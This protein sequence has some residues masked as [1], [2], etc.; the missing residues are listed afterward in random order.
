M[1]GGDVANTGGGPQRAERIPNAPGHALKTR[2]QWLNPKEF[3]VPA[4]FTFGNERRNDLVGPGYLNVDFNARKDFTMERLTIQFRC[5]F[6]NLFNRTQLAL[7]S[8][9][10]QSSAF[11]SI[12][13]T[14]APAREIQFVLK[15]L[16]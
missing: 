15:A 16:F 6:F 2:Q 8:N 11:G 10:V 1:A 3:T 12:T 5:E 13:S 14:S 4:P 7:P 9:N